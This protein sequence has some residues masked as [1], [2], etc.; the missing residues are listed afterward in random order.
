MNR[1]SLKQK[2]VKNITV[3]K[4]IFSTHFVTI[5]AHSAILLVGILGTKFAL[6]HSHYSQL[7][8]LKYRGLHNK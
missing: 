6:L 2:K 5:L 8:T 3:V 4:S 1:Y 7:Y